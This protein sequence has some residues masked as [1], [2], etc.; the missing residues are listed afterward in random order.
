MLEGLY[1]DSTAGSLI[2][3]PLLAEPV[4][5]SWSFRTIPIWKAKPAGRRHRLTAPVLGGTAQE[6]VLDHM[7]GSRLRCSL[8]YLPVAP[9]CC[10]RAG[11]TA[12]P[13]TQDTASIQMSSLSITVTEHLLAKAPESSNVALGLAQGFDQY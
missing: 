11:V 1:H 13:T 7:L 3:S 9:P 2:P 4:C 12:V 5:H 6:D 10:W 8:L